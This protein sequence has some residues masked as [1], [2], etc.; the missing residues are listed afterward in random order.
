MS[1]PMSNKNR[2]PKDT[3]ARMPSAQTFFR[4]MTLDPATGDS[5]R[6]TMMRLNPLLMLRDGAQV[7]KIRQAA[8]VEEL[9]DL[10]PA[11]TGLA[12]FAFA[13]R[14]RQFGSEALPALTARLLQIKTLEPAELRAMT[15]EKLI[16]ACAWHAAAGAYALSACFAA[17][18]DYG[19]SLACMVLGVLGEH[20]AADQIWAFYNCVAPN[21]NESYLVGP[22][23][24]LTDLG[25]SRGAGAL[26]DLV[27]G[28]QDFYELYGLLALGGDARAVIP[29]AEASVLLPE[30]ERLDAL[31]ALIAI[32]HRI[33]RA[34]LV[35]ELQQAV[36]PGDA[37]VTAEELADAILAKPAAGAGGPEEYFELFYH[38]PRPAR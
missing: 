23:W 6:K 38:A 5:V 33:G 1:Q 30:A 4:L 29:L 18:D 14:L 7:K 22:L 32:G 34:A 12:D 11:A 31:M 8:T 16:A 15:A 25:D 20:A 35:A 24:G 37:E 3:S 17:L 27:R 19:K 10:L 9:F 13:E 28:K 21:M 36:A 26:A 2:P